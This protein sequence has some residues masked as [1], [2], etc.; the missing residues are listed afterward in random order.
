M[1][2]NNLEIINR[3]IEG[4]TILP[5]PKDCCQECAVKHKPNEPHN[6]QSFF[7]QYK[8]NLKHGRAATWNDAIAHC[9][10]KVKVYWQGYLKAL[11]IDPNSTNLTGNLKSE[12]EVK[13]VL[14]E[15]LS[16]ENKQ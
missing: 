15:F 8:F 3:G 11:G 12:E 4:L 16:N 2:K 5:P 7:Y 14:E 9:P 6:P 1:K 10:V 13:V